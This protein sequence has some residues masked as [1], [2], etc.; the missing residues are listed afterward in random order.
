MNSSSY[1]S[2]AAPLTTQGAEAVAASVRA[3]EKPNSLRSHTQKV[4]WHP[5]GDQVRSLTEA[6]GKCGGGMN[7]EG[8]GEEGEGSEVEWRGRAG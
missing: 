4:L 7:W 2:L 8:R 3:I 1:S 5:K 6:I